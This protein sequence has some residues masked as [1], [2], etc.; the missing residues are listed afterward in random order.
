MKG[1]NASTANIFIKEEANEASQS[2]IYLKYAK[3][4]WTVFFLL[5]FVIFMARMIFVSRRL[6]KMGGYMEN[7][8]STIQATITSS[9][10]VNEYQLTLLN[11]TDH[12]GEGTIEDLTSQFKEIINSPSMRLI[13]F[14]HSINS[15]ATY[16]P[17]ARNSLNRG[18]EYDE[19]DFIYFM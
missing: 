1:F 7:M 15:Y 2:N 6:S 17:S 19:I 4:V 3:Y 10:L 18:I 12:D 11:I 8:N 16:P 13:I 9:R 5:F 14:D